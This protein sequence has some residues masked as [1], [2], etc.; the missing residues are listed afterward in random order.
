M[1]LRGLALALSYVVELVLVP[2][3]VLVVSIGRGYKTFFFS[4]PVDGGER[5]VLGVSFVFAFLFRCVASVQLWKRSHE[6]AYIEQITNRKIT[7]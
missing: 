7:I 3:R 6:V 5:P 4:G 2:R 1:C